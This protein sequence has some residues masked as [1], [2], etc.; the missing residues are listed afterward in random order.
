MKWLESLMFGKNP[1]D[2][3][4]L[5][6]TV[7]VDFKFIQFENFFYLAKRKMCAARY[8]IEWFANFQR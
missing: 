7:N 2:F 1:P 4:E 8:C 6:P 3:L 5:M